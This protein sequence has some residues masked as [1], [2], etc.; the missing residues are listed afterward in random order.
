MYIADFKKHNIFAVNL[1]TKEIRVH[2]HA[3]A[4]NQPNDL[5]ITEQGVLF[6]SHP[7]WIQQN[8][9]Q[10]WRIH[11]NGDTQLLERNMGTTNGIEVSPDGKKLYVN[12][13]LQRRVWVYDLSST[14]E[15]SNKRLLV[16]FRDFELDGMRCDVAGNLFV[17]RPGKGVVAKISPD[18]LY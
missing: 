4:M 5:A 7:N 17:T 3:P 10:L 13:S 11:T 9:G 16:E 15:L 1:E 2:A 18:G 12:E 14:Y 6:A 8:K